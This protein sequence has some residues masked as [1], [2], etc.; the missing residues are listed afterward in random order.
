LCCCNFRLSAL[1]GVVFAFVGVVTNKPHA[2]YT[3]YTAKSQLAVARH[4]RCRHHPQ[5]SSFV[6]VVTNKPHAKY[7]PYTAKSQLAVAS[8]ARCR[9]YPQ[10][11]SF[12]GDNTNKGIKSI[13]LIADKHIN[14]KTL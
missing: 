9:W 10:A 7:T 2:K 6:G 14:V 13:T 8:H 11:S 4:A 5:A 12:V 1:V 3:P